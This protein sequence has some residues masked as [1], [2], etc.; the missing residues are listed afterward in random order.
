MKKSAK[1]DLK[2]LTSRCFH[3]LLTS[4]LLSARLADTGPLVSGMTFV[5]FVGVAKPL[6]S[7]VVCTC[8]KM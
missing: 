7:V 2:W 4:G 5:E 6:R 1:Q 3:I 8:C